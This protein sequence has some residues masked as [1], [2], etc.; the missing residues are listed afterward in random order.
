MAQD[1]ALTAN[2]A[3]LAKSPDN[4]RFRTWLKAEREH[5]RDM[6]ETTRDPAL[7][8]IAQGHAQMIKDI[9]AAMDTAAA[10]R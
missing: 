8:C 5:W 10:E 3:R 6:L 9:Q 7:V 4:E 1:Q 2:F